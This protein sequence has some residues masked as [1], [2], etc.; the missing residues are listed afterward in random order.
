MAVL[1]DYGR[2]YNFSRCI[3]RTVQLYRYASTGVALLGTVDNEQL[4]RTIPPHKVDRCHD[5]VDFSVFYHQ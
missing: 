1:T 4:N 3:Y 2:R 5:K